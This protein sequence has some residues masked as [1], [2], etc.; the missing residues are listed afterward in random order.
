MRNT[1]PHLSE[2]GEEGEC[3]E[4]SVEKDYTIKVSRDDFGTL[5]ICALRYA[6]GRETY[7]PDLV[8]SI[9]KQHLRDMEQK[10]IEVML[11]DCAWQYQHEVY[12]NPTIDK[13]GWVLWEQIIRIEKERRL[14]GDGGDE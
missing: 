13:P 9:V 5:A 7:M 8:R 14:K 4:M 11:Q 3:K 2:V 1:T 6:M 10:D 12:G